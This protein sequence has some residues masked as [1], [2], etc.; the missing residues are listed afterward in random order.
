MTT[1][2]TVTPI[3]VSGATF[4]STAIPTCD[5]N[6]ATQPAE[7]ASYSVGA[8][9]NFPFTG[10]TNWA[11][12]DVKNCGRPVDHYA[13]TATS[14]VPAIFANTAVWENQSIKS[15]GLSLEVAP[16][17]VTVALLQGTFTQCLE[18]NKG[19]AIPTYAYDMKD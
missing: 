17:E 7:C 12:L 19:M 5:I 14:P 2:T 10:I 9:Y 18:W 1:K 4:Q 8:V 3:S 13:L 15:N 6:A 16:E 11:C